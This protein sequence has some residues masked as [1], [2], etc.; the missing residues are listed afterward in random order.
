MIPFDEV[1]FR[2]IQ[3]QSIRLV[4]GMQE[5]LYCGL[6]PFRGPGFELIILGSKSS[7]PHQ[8]SHQR[9]IFIC[10]LFSSSI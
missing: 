5:F 7:A 3:L 8:V 6:V 4:F 1:P 9:N 10:H 2:Q